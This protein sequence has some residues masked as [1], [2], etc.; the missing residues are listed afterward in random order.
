MARATD[1]VDQGV[2]AGGQI[3]II[4]SITAKDVVRGLELAVER[5]AE[6]IVLQRVLDAKMEPLA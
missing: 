5:S 3:V 6:V 1:R 4:R 2:T